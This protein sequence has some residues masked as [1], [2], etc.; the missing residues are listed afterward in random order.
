M[1]VLER[2]RQRDRER[3]CERERPMVHLLHAAVNISRDGGLE[4][5][6]GV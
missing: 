6:I 5:D 2:E 3:E 4:G 1:C